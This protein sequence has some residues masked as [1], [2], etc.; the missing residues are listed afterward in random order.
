MTG[1]YL[2]RTFICTNSDNITIDDSD[3][4]GKIKKIFTYLHRQF[5]TYKY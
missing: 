1:K 5:I 3:D 4:T 2:S